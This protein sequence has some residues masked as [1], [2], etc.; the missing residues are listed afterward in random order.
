MVDAG[1]EPTYE[2]KFRVPPPPGNVRCIVD[3]III[4]KANFMRKLQELTYVRGGMACV[5]SKSL[6]AVNNLL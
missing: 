2:E 5:T 6:F 4:T 1:P 3:T